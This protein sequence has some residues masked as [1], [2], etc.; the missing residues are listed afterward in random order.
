MKYNLT[1]TIE[2][3]DQP[4]PLRDAAAAML[5]EHG[6]VTHSACTFSLPRFVVR[7]VNTDKRKKAPEAFE[8]TVQ[9]ES[10]DEAREQIASATHIVS[11]VEPVQ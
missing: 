7:G 1:F 6:T 2:T 11:H 8:E 5:S 4:E 9:A 10:V 3:E